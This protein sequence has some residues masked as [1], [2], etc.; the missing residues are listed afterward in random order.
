MA[1][2]SLDNFIKT[3]V[4]GDKKLEIYNSAGNLMY[5]LEPLDVN[6]YYRNNKVV[7]HQLRTRIEREPCRYHS[8]TELDFDTQDIA[9]QAVIVANDAKNLILTFTDYY[10]T[11]EIDEK[12]QEL[13][14]NDLSDVNTGGT[15][16]GYYLSYSGGTWIGVPDSTDLS[17]YYTKIEVYNSGQTDVLLENYYTSGETDIILENYYTSGETDEL[18]SISIWTFDFMDDLTVDIYA[19]FNIRIRN[20]ANVVN[21]PTTIITVNSNPYSLDDVIISGSL[22][23]IT[24]N[25]NSVINLTVKS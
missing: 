19:P 7:I 1:N 10:N 23:T 12:F 14:I 9:S 25:I 3:P 2:Y 15:S 16:N 21:T 5:M 8:Y 20:I 24:V 13:V 18:F 22:I 6:F 11:G 4:D 17:N